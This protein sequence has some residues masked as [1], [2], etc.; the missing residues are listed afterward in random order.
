[1]FVFMFSPAKC[2]LKYKICLPNGA[3]CPLL[4]TDFEY[5]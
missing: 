2:I 4:N 1:M 5:A 3:E